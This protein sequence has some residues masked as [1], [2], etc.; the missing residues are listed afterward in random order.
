[1]WLICYALN[2]VVRCQPLRRALVSIKK[3]HKICVNG[4]DN[5]DFGA[6]SLRIGF[7]ALLDA[8]EVESVE[9]VVGTR[10][11]KPINLDASILWKRPHGKFDFRKAATLL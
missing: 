2:W 7:G 11:L 6:Q 4:F 10:S 9:N 5:S 3:I 8:D 1:M